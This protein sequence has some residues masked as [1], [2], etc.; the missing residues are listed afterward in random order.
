MK[1]I[2]DIS[3]NA[4]VTSLLNGLKKEGKRPD[5]AFKALEVGKVEGNLLASKEFQL[6]ERYVKM[7][8]QKD[9]EEILAGAMTA[10]LGDDVFSQK[11][12]EAMKNPSTR[13]LAAT[14]EAAQLSRWLKNDF[15]PVAILKTQ[16]LDKA[17]DALF[18]SPQYATWLNFVEAYNK[19]NPQKEMSVLDAFTENYGEKGIMKLLGSLDDGPQATKFK[20][21][22]VMTVFN[23]E[24]PFAETTMIQTFT[25]SY[26]EEKVATMIQAAT[27]NPETEHFAKNLQSAQFKQ[28]MSEKKT[29]D[30]VYKKVL[31]LDSTDSP[32]AD[33][34]RAYYNAYDEQY[35]GKL[36]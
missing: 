20:D 24:Y 33:I 6:L 22:V 13:E 36:F 19:K 25:K 35:P 15:T 14:L 27:K 9:P 18:D 26:G 4:Q 30:V 5:Q 2:D 10:N 3:D 29:P 34:W 11:M 31:K 17:T 21:E 16:K 32:N 1:K 28:W 12:A 8:N 23:K 7:T